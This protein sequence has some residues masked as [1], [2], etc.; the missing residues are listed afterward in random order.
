MQ[1]VR[2]Y[3]PDR[4]P[5][6]WRQLIRPDQYV[7]FAQL[8]SGAPCDAEGTPFSS[9]D[10]GTCVLFD[11]LTEATTFC[12]AQARRVPALRFDIYDAAGLVAPPLLTVLHPSREVSAER[13]QRSRRSTYL[14]AGLLVVAGPALI[15]LDWSQFG[16]LKILP[17][18]LGINCLYFH[19]FVM[20]ARSARR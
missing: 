3:D 17:T 6:R 13:R 7:A 8:D 10:L 18:F 20:G 1:T 2:V 12:R 16:G 5:P 9:P 15:W 14:A 19:H 11:S 4:Q